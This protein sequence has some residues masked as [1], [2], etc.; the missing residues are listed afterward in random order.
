VGRQVNR[1]AL[2]G[3]SGPCKHTE[4]IEVDARGAMTISRINNRVIRE[5]VRVNQTLDK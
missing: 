3:S 1:G 5:M 2:C 4:R